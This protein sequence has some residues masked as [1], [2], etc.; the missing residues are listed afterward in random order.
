MQMN[1]A[2][3]AIASFMALGL[4][5]EFVGAEP[6]HLITRVRFDGVAVA[7]TGDHAPGVI[8]GGDGDEIADS[9]AVGSHLRFLSF[10]VDAPIISTPAHPAT[11]FSASLLI[12]NVSMDC[13][14]CQMLGWFEGGNGNDK[15]LNRWDN[16]PIVI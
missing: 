3:M 1:S 12:C 4:R 2:S 14:D 8:G 9:E 11:H 5:L 10:R 13:H 15:R 6:Q 7:V 16:Q